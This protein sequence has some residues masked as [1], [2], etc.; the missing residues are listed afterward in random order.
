MP[1]AAINSKASDNV[2][3][4]YQPRSE[5]RRDKCR[6]STRIENKTAFQNVDIY[7]FYFTPPTI[8]QSLLGRKGGIGI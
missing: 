8:L 6:T 1:Q 2:I 3:R 4:A 5:K 7:Y